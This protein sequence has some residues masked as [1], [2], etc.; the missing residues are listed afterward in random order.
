MD[1]TA[2]QESIMYF[3]RRESYMNPNMKPDALP[4]SVAVRSSRIV[5]ELTQRGFEKGSVSKLPN[6]HD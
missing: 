5:F 2:E 1:G 6:L 3:L 4:N